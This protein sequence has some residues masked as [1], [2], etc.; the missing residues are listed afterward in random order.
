VEDEESLLL[1]SSDALETQRETK[2][3]LRLL[4][5][6]SRT[7][8]LTARPS[9]S[10]VSVGCLWCWALNHMAAQHLPCPVPALGGWSWYG[11][12]AL[13]SFVS[14]CLAI[15]AYIVCSIYAVAGLELE[16]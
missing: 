5:S 2:K 11:G 8:L 13:V 12:E 6:L 4:L 7:F 16:V 14:M 3:K 9:A 15:G 1:S 10:C